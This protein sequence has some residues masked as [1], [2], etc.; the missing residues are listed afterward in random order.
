MATHP[1]VLAQ[2]ALSS[3]LDVDPCMIKLSGL[4]L[5][6]HDDAQLTPVFVLVD[7]GIPPW[8]HSCHNDILKEAI[9]YL[10]LSSNVEPMYDWPEVM[11]VMMMVMMMMMMMMMVMMMIM[12]MTMMMLMVRWG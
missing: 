10:R 4:K 9:R 2:R 1:V 7:N 5:S 11:M 8:L 3:S 6:G 12:M